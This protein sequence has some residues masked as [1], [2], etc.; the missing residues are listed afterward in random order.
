MTDFTL[1]AWNWLEVVFHTYQEESASSK[2]FF[3]FVLEPPAL[4]TQGTGDGPCKMF[5]LSTH[6]QE[7]L[8]KFMQLW[9][10]F[11]I[12]KGGK[13]ANA[14]LSVTTSILIL[15]QII[16]FMLVAEFFL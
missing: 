12:Y 9:W 14:N 11:Q 5:S 10:L 3:Q 4:H 1:K 8:E 16:P 6:Q 13:K 15:D 7:N 2:W